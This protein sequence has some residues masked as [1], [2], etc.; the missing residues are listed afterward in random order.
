MSTLMDNITETTL[1]NGIEQK[2]KNAIVDV[3]GRINYNAN[4][5]DVP[6][7][8][9]NTLVGNKVNGVILKG[10]GDVKISPTTHQDVVT[11]TISTDVDTFMMKRPYYASNNLKFGNMM[12]SQELFNDLFDNVLNNVKG[13]YDGDITKTDSSGN[14]IN[15]WSNTY[16][17][18]IGNKYGLVPNA[19]YLRLYLTSQPEPL[20][21]LIDTDIVDTQPIP[22]DV[23]DSIC[24]I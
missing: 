20:Y 16:Y 2:I 9:R 22:N 8:I 21:I 13:V 14:D 23:I 3:G 1:V 12:S 24:T 18:C 5:S 11:Y 4:L 17:E 15:I 19:K 6:N 7:I 10:A